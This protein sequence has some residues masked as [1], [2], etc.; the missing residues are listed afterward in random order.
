MKCIRRRKQRV[1]QARLESRGPLPEKSPKK[2]KGRGKV[3]EGDTEGPRHG[4]EMKEEAM[5]A[6]K[7]V[8]D[9]ASHLGK[10][11]AQ[12]RNVIVVLMDLETE[13]ARVGLSC[14]PVPEAAA[15]CNWSLKALTTKGR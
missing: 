3:A 15:A 8:R 5:Y 13:S 6:P 9:R 4:G 12:V 14:S 11:A 10:A 1:R 2:G 7:R